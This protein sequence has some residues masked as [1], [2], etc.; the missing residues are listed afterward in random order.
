M[1]RHLSNSGCNKLREKLDVLPSISPIHLRSSHKGKGR[2]EK[3]PPGQFYNRTREVTAMQ[4]PLPNG[5][6]PRAV[7][8]LHRTTRRAVSLDPTPTVEG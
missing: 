5:R 8:L 7:A 3:K 6:E 2:A 4:R 1:K